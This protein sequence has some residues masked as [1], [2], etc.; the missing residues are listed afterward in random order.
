MWALWQ[1]KDIDTK[2]LR[3]LMVQSSD[4]AGKNMPRVTEQALNE[5]LVTPSYSAPWQKAVLRTEK[6]RRDHWHNIMKPAWVGGVF[7]AL[8]GGVAG[9]IITWALSGH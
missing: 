6:E 8:A 3:K 2:E 9:A 7:G 1:K 4:I 5:A